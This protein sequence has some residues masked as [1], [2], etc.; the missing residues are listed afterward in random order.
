MYHKR[1]DGDIPRTKRGTYSW[2]IYSFVTC[3]TMKIVIFNPFASCKRT[4]VV[5]LTCETD[6]GSDEISSENIIIISY[7]EHDFSVS[8]IIFTIAGISRLI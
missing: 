6:P 8:H 7:H 4:L 1:R 3:P 5:S 2:F